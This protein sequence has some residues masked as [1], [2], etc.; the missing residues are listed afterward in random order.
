MTQGDDKAGAGAPAAVPKATAVKAGAAA[1]AATSPGS[2]GAQLPAPPPWYATL[3]QEPPSWLGKVI[4]LAC[5]LLVLVIWY[6]F[7]AGDTPDARAISPSKLPSPGEV[8]GAT[9]ELAERNLL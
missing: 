9:D 1:A 6:L 7:T 2:G 3:R 5:V 8:F 4:G